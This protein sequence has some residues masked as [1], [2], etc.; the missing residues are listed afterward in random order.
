MMDNPLIAFLARRRSVSALALV[1]P[2]P[3]ADTLALLLEIAARV[4]DHG[5]LAPWR[6]V[7]IEGAAKEH[8]ADALEAI[9][10]GT[11]DASKRGAALR[12]LRQP[13][14]CICVVSSVKEA[15]IPEWE[16]VL[17]AGAVCMNLLSAA[18]ALGFGANWLT[19][20]YAYD[21]RATALL[22]LETGERIAG[23]IMIGTAPNPP[24]ERPRPAA[25]EL[26]TRL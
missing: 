11:P 16:Q 10:A 13:P 7:V 15:H 3:D 17:S 24:D 21:Q 9:V 26:T 23:M 1:D 25:A 20:W 14:L 18:L 8:Y 2:A 4:P 22:N 19:D 12:K 6:F 5:K